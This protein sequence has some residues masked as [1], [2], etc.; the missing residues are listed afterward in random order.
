LYVHN[1]MDK[2]Q[3]INASAKGMV[4]KKG[5]ALRRDYAE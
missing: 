5:K 4:R 3:G 2:E 1:R